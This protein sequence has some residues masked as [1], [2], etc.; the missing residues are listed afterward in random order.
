LNF[1]WQIS[2]EDVTLQPKNREF[3]KL[4]TLYILKSA[5]K[6]RTFIAEFQAV[7][8]VTNNPADIVTD[9]EMESDIS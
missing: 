6:I 1:T 9:K 3:H 2:R 5:E 8:Q 4:L 7:M